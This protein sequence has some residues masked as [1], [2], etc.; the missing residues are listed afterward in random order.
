MNFV[1]FDIECASVNKTTAK[2]CAFGY[3]VC[4]EQF[5]IISKEDILINPRG[6]FHLTD[7]NGKRGLVLPYSYSEF[8]KY[9]P[10]TQVYPFIKSLL[11]DK[12]NVVMG[13]SI[14]NDVKYLN[15]ETR[16]F[17]L[18]SF[19]F[20]FLDSQLMFMS[21]SGD[22]S[23]QCG[24]EHIAVD[25]GV[26][27]I[28]HRAV[29]DAYATMRVVQAICN[30]EKCDFEGLAKLYGLSRGRIRNYFIYSPSSTGLKT[31]HRNINEE[32][33][34]RRQ[35]RVE[36]FNYISRKKLKRG[37]KFYGKVFSFSRE[38][39]DDTQLAKSLCDAIY[40]TGGR[41]SHHLTDCNYYVC[42]ENDTS[43]RT[44]NARGVNG[45]VMLDVEGL[46]KLLDD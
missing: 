28:P 12:N 23:R 15:L 19:D 32:K 4:D 36:L 40:L 11:E 35:K 30:A 24:L 1:F 2:I 26:E 37:G 5:N 6:S 42:A 31:Y 18:P 16:R 17:S 8:K 25:L 39:E 44:E 22:F 33:K 34:L 9:P 41:Y 27:F 29:D 21:Y 7:R 10:F 46:E 20:R 43:Q 14:L 38:I 13:H 3:V 45:M